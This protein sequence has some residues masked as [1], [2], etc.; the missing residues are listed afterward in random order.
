MSPIIST[1]AQKRGHCI[2]LDARAGTVELRRD[3]TLAAADQTLAF[4]LSELT[5]LVPVRVSRYEIGC[6]HASHED[7]NTLAPARERDVAR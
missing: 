5:M 6:R 1:R 3:A 2:A 4:Q 7:S